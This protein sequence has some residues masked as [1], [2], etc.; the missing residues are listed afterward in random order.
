MREKKSYTEIMK[1]HGK[2][3]KLLHDATMIDVYIQMVIDAA[4]YDR[5]KEL[6]LQ[7]IDAALDCRNNELFM[8]LSQEYNNL[9]KLSS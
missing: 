1:S 4:I 3:Q 7:K 2:D 9:L 8:N 5:K 6:L